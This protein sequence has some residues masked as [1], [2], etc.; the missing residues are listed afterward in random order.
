MMSRHQLGQ[1][2]SKFFEQSSHANLV[3]QSQSPMFPN[4]KEEDDSMAIM[5][6]PSEHDEMGSDSKDLLDS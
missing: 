3:L 5:P 2:N 1:V 4:K 6:I